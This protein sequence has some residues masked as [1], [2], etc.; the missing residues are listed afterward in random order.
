MD[1]GWPTGNGKK[2]SNTQACCLAQ[3]CLAPAY[4]LSISCGQSHVRR[5]YIGQMGAI[6]IKILAKPA[7]I[8]KNIELNRMEFRIWLVLTEHDG[9]FSAKASD[10]PSGTDTGTSF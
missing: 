6:H 8:P 5:L 7:V 3:Q 10:I 2:L 9:R 1:I 4:F